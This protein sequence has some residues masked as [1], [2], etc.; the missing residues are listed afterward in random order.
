[1]NAIAVT[2]LWF[3]PVCQDSTFEDSNGSAALWPEAD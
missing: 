2:T 1:V 3:T